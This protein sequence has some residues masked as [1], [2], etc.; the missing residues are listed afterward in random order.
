MLVKER[1]HLS[2]TLPEAR[3]TLSSGMNFEPAYGKAADGMR[4][5]QGG[6]CLGKKVLSVAYRLQLLDTLSKKSVGIEPW[7]EYVSDNVFDA[8]F[9]KSQFFAA[10]NRRVDQVEP[11]SISAVLIDDKDWIRIVPQPFAHLLA[12]TAI[13][14]EKEVNILEVKIDNAWKGTTFR[15]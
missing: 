7:Q 9:H 3:A 15:I 1:I 2:I 10:H 13:E 11:E 14:G 12:I 5:K 4:T 8:L 6:N